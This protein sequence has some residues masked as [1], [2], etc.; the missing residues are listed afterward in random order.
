MLFQIVHSSATA[1]YTL[2]F[3]LFMWASRIPRTNPGSGWWAGAAAC[4]ALSRLLLLWLTTT[5]HPRAALFLY[6]AFAIE[7]QALLAIGITQFFKQNHHYRKIIIT[8]TCI[9][10]WTAYGWLDGVSMWAF[11]V[12]LS[13]YNVVIMGFI[14]VVCTRNR[15]QAH[16]G[17]A[18]VTAVAACLLVVHWASY[19]LTFVYPDWDIIGYGVGT[20]L[21]LILFLSLLANTLA[22]FQQRLIEAET[23]ALDLA[24]RDPLTGLNNKNHL[25]RLFD[26]VL[27]LA[28]RPHHLVAVIYID[29]DEFKPINDTGGHKTGDEVLKAVA[30]RL[31]HHTRSTDI[32]ARIGGDEFIIVATQLKRATSVE[33]IATKL[34]LQLNQDVSIG[35]NTYPLGASMGISLYPLHGTTLGQ[36]IEL[37]DKAMYQAKHKGKGQYVIYSDDTDGERA[38]EACI[39]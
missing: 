22:Q 6:A 35:E 21:A 1:I 34:L 30:Q 25:I 26:Q 31:T 5:H 36:L 11:S 23:C 29:L 27:T 10:C 37:A 15:H 9:G 14:A 19:P 20:I 4:M 28:T 38:S 12:G 7:G 3:V 39:C 18:F 13:I 17:L 24:Y 16:Q 8:V 2:L 32:T 33:R